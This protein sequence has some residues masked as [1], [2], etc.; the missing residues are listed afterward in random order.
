MDSQPP[1]THCL[2]CGAPLRFEPAP[3]FCPACGQETRLHPPTLGE[4]AHELIGHYVAI[5]GALWRSLAALVFVPGKLTREYLDGRRR[6]YV[7][8]LR[9]HL[10]ASFLFFLVVKV[11]GAGA[12][13]ELQVK[14]ASDPTVQAEVA[15][16]R[17]CVERPGDC[18]RWEA[19]I[20]RHTLRLIDGGPSPERAETFN[21]RMAAAAPYAVFVLLPVFAAIVHGA[22]WRRRLPYGAH[23]VFGL[24]MHAVWF[25]AMLA[26]ALLPE[27]AMLALLPLVFLHG[28]LALRRVYGGSVMVTLARGVFVTAVYG[29]AIG[30]GT[31]MLLWA[32]ALWH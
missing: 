9:L 31:V 5:E 23:F 30:I 7:L 4:F 11:L 21:Q 10:S 25:M 26:L 20:A 6:R 32:A 3:S 15:Q 2:N 1:P 22:Y 17:R 13:M 28:L 18:G 16:V 12:P 19:W 14:S 27:A 29:L 8:P 24:H